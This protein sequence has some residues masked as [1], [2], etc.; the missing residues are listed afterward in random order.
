LAICCHH[1]KLQKPQQVNFP[2][3]NFP[4]YISHHVKF[5]EKQIEFDALNLQKASASAFIA[6]E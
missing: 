6:I 3:Q 1:S 4:G 5:N 2:F